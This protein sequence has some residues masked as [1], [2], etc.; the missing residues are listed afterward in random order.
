MMTAP[1]KPEATSHLCRRHAAQPLRQIASWGRRRLCSPGSP[2]ISALC[3]IPFG[4][5]SAASPL[6]LAWSFPRPMADHATRLGIGQPAPASRDSE[7]SAWLLPIFPTVR[8][9]SFVLVLF[10]KPTLSSR[11]LVSPGVIAWPTARLC[12]RSTP[13]VNSFLPTQTIRRA[14]ILYTSCPC[15]SRMISP[16][17]RTQQPGLGLSRA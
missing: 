9:I 1:P 6:I 14:H 15:P 10:L 4:V 11:H 16:T 7:R 8:A 13:P 3:P 17:G 2:P 5:V 12:A